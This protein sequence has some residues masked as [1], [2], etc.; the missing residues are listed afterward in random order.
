MAVAVEKSGSQRWVNDASGSQ[1]WGLFSDWD[2]TLRDVPLRCFYLVAWDRMMLVIRV[3]MATA[4]A[5][6]VATNAFCS[7][8]VLFKGYC[9]LVQ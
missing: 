3:M 5:A 2:L 6:A 9:F 1:R 8:I 4:T 7:I